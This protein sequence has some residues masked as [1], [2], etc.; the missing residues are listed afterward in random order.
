MSELEKAKAF[1]RSTKDALQL[2]W[3]ATNKGQRS[4]LLRNEQIK[5]M[6]ERY[7]IVTEEAT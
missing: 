7:E 5:T 4:K 1:N 2:I 6:L 3:N